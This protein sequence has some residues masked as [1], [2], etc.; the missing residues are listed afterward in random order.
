MEALFEQIKG[1]DSVFSQ[2]EY[3]ADSIV[4]HAIESARIAE[5]YVLYSDHKDVIM[6]FSANKEV[7]KVWI[8]TSSVVRE[9]TQK[10]INICRFLK[11]QGIDKPEI[12][13]KKEISDSMSDLYAVASGELNY[14]VRDEYSLQIFST[15]SAFSKV[16]LSA[17]EKIVKLD[18]SKDSNRRL[19][20]NF[21]RS[22]AE[23]FRW[24]TKFDRK[25]NEY[26]ALEHYALIKDGRIISNAVVGS[27]TE[28]YLRVKS[29][30]TVADMRKQ[31]YAH[32]VLSYVTKEI[33]SKGKAPILYAH[34]GNKAAMALWTKNNYKSYGKLSLLKVGSGVRAWEIAK[35]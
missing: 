15:D 27:P 12:Y 35:K 28:V 24:T 23:E 6:L 3:K 13:M 29:I 5:G 25:I 4:F 22:L 16:E 32:K 31:G 8:W 21:Y 18:M 10:I 7:K 19:L 2:E 26:F 14:E 33:L 30:A 11:N 17:G 1:N 34:I 20:T 9:D